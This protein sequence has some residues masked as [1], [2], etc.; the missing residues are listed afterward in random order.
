MIARRNFLFVGMICW[1]QFMTRSVWAIELQ[2]DENFSWELID[3][4]HAPVYKQIRKHPDTYAYLE[5]VALYR[6][7]YRSDGLKITGLMAAPKATGTFPVVVY[8]R[9]GNRDY[10]QLLV[11]TA[12]DVLA[13][14]AAEGYVVVASNYRGNGGSEGAEEFGGADVMDVVNL[15]KNCSA[16]EKADNR[17]IGLFGVSRGGMMNYLVLRGLA[18]YGIQVQCAI[19][20]GGI[21]DLARTIEYHPE[22]GTV[23]E[24]IV[25]DYASDKFA[26]NQKRSAIYWAGEL[27]ETCP[28]LIL[29]SYDDAAVTYLQIPAFADSLDK[30][31]RPYQLI[32]FKKD[33]HG[34]VKHREFVQERINAWL[35]AYLKNDQSFAVAEKRLVVE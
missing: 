20:V 27:P 11:S 28:L 25:P 15:A 30:Y 4:T 29:H 35:N 2:A 10:G 7:L 19:S 31:Q 34:I 6:I 12:T 22:I 17:R 13:P 32:S 8:N 33:N 14:I 18:N 24:E 3:Y 5:Q 26:A 16:Y 9:G 23:C 21:A 1:F